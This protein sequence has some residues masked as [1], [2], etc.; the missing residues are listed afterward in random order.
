VTSAI[1]IGIVTSA[2]TSRV[3]S[4][5]ATHVTSA[6]AAHGASAEA[7]TVPAAAATTVSAAAATT[8]TTTTTSAATS[9]RHCRRSQ[10]NGRNSQQREYLVTQHYHSPLQIAPRAFRWRSLGKPPLVFTGLLI[11]PD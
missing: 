11:D 2:K 3:S 5:E 1:A 4:S 9:Q 10:A 8:T 7:T 6:E